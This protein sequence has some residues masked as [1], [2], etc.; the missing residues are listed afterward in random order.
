MTTEIIIR[1]TAEGFHHWPGAPEK[2]AY[3]ADSHR[4]LFYVEVALEVFKQDR[5]VEFH[6]LLDLSRDYFGTGDF[7]AQSC[8]TLAHNLLRVIIED[9]PGRDVA[10]SVF[11]DNEVG[12]RVRYVHHQ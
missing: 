4:H 5:E 12:A 2:R 8:E 10:V 1:F 7:G 9:F 3:L 6:D 11:E